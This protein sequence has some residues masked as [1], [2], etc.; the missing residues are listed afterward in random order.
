M[1]IRGLSG[2]ARDIYNKSDYKSGDDKLMF[3]ELEQS[4]I[5]VGDLLRNKEELGLK[6]YRDCIRKTNQ[7]STK[8]VLQKVLRVH[9]DHVE[10]LK[11]DLQNISE[12]KVDSNLVSELEKGVSSAELCEEFDF[13]TLTFTEATRLAIRFAENDIRFYENF[14]EKDLDNP[15]RQAI[16]RILYKKSTYVMQLKSEYER[17]R[18]KNEK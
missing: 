1:L 6:F 12:D 15:S 18:Y 16:E 5:L 13:A 4:E 14:L 9:Q 17:L 8:Y 7:F 3:K 11:L 2:F 10:D